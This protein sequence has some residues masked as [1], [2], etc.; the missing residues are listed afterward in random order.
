MVPMLAWI[1]NS[2]PDNLKATFFAVMASFS[3]LALSAGQLGTKYLNEIF[4]VTREVKDPISG[5]VSVPAD[6]S[7]LGDLMITALAIG[8][9][10]PLA[11]VALVKVMRLRSA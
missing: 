3:N 10:L 7:Q 8:L 2:A 6:Y 9:V 4:L 1:A 5:V 11:A